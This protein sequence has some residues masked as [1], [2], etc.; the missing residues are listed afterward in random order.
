MSQVPVALMT[1]FAEICAHRVEQLPRAFCQDA[2]ISTSPSPSRSMVQPADS[3]PDISH[4]ELVCGSTAAKPR[5]L[6]TLNRLPNLKS[7]GPRCMSL[8]GVLNKDTR[9]FNQ[10][11]V[12]SFSAAVPLLQ[13][14]HAFRR[15]M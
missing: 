3:S 5:R 13:A 10:A 12:I 2:S 1:M 4:T 9:A 6:Y 11:S 8:Y 15:N 7:D 14:Y